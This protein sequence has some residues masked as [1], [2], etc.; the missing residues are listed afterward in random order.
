MKKYDC[1]HCGQS[2]IKDYFEESGLTDD[3]FI[4][5]CRVC[6]HNVCQEH[7]EPCCFCV[8]NLSSGK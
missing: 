5:P 2:M 4:M 8:H 7:E 6:V 1:P 3:S